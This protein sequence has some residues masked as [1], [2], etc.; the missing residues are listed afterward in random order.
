ME[1]GYSVALAASS[2][3]G[4]VATRDTQISAQAVGGTSSGSSSSG[5][6][7]STIAAASVFGVLFVCVAMFAVVQTR[8]L[9]ALQGAKS[10]PLLEPVDETYASH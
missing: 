5:S 2:S 1:P 8:K 3:A 10:Q 9:H 6:N 4:V 7:A